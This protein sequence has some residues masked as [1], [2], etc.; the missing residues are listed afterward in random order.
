MMRS[1]LFTAALVMALILTSSHES[2][3]QKKKAATA[4]PAA[5]IKWSEMKGGPPGLMYS[6]LWGDITKGAYGT[7]VKHPAGSV[8]PLHTHSA[9]VKL[10]VLSGTFLYTPEGGTE[11]QLG[12]G[13]YLMVPGGLRH[14]SGTS[15]DGPCEVLQISSAK[16]DLIPVE[17]A[18]K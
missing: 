15:A 16:F 10:V 12:P 13:S 7:L 17:E 1:L 14:S 8:H 2:Y 4:W 5:D 6:N 9:D 3:A 18:K 11:V